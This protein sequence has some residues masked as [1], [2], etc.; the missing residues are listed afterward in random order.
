KRTPFASTF[1]RGRRNVLE[2]DVP[3]GSQMLHVFMTHIDREADRQAQ[4]GALIAMFL[5]HPSPAVVMGDFN[6]EGTDPML[7]QL[8]QRP[9]VIDCLTRTLETK[10]PRTNIDWIF[11]KGVTVRDAGLIDQGASDHPLAWAQVE[12][13]RTTA[14]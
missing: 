5:A 7:M 2:I 4:L 9:E 13:E 10:L 3:F 14:T 6:T 1:G 8:R 12:A 11:V